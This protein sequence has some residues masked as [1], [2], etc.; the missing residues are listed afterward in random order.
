MITSKIRTIFRYIWICIKLIWYFFERIFLLA[1]LLFLTIWLAWWTSQ[2]PSLYRDWDPLDAVLPTVSWSWDLVSIENIRNNTW[3]TSTEY[4]PG[5]LSGTYDIKDVERVHY[6]ITPFS[7]SDGPAHTMLTFTFSG[8]RHLAISGEIRKERGEWFDA[9]WGVLNK[10]EL[11]YVIATEEDIIKLRTN[12]RKNEVYMYPIN[13]PKENIELLLRS[14]LMRADKLTK[15]PE[16][17]N[18]IWNNCTTSIL[19]HANALRKE[20]L[21]GGKYIIL[22]SHS[23]EIVYAAGLIDTKLPLAEA[24]AYYRIDQLAQSSA[25]TTD[26]SSII[27]KPIQ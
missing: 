26:F 2:K 23:D 11:L 21:D 25:E 16:F 12:H 9:L 1:F 10:F 27:R 8:G 13:T 5:L 24:R 15:E 19:A 4:T 3:I 17:Y 6:V 20:K 18:T 22:P 14:M 7:D